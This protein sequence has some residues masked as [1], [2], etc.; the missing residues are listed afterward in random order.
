MKY[1]YTRYFMKENI[2][3]LSRY[4]INDNGRPPLMH[5][6][7]LVYIY[8]ICIITTILVT[9]LDRIHY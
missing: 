4:V 1:K 9:T 3:Y 6:N 5:A 2:E 8:A 7:Y